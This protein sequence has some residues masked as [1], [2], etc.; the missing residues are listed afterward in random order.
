MLANSTVFIYASA[1]FEALFNT[2]ALH[3]VPVVGQDQ[4]AAH[5]SCTVDARSSIPRTSMQHTNTGCGAAGDSRRY[6][7]LMP[8]S[9]CIHCTCIFPAAQNPTVNLMLS[10]LINRNCEEGLMRK[11]SEKSN[12]L[13]KTVLMSNIAWH[14]FPKCLTC[15]SASCLYYSTIN[16]WY[17]FP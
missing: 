1:F 13:T 3:G 12:M 6:I 16:H 11:A 17:F 7:M 14:I 2:S 5:L 8:K 4:Y 15:I 9:T 10:F